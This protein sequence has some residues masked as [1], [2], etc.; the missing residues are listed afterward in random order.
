MPR[1][2]LV[3]TDPLLQ[4]AFQQLLAEEGHFCA[5]VDSAPA[6]LRAIRNDAFDLVVLD[7]GRF[8]DE[9]LE[10]VVAIRRLQQGLNE[11]DG[12]LSAFQSFIAEE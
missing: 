6:A 3:E 4:R 2:L 11:P 1:L 8:R 10:L 12:T 5:L 7:V 9:G